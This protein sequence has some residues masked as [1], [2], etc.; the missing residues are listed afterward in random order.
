[1]RG[2]SS[3][4]I[5]RIWKDGEMHGIGKYTME[6]GRYFDGSFKTWKILIHAEP[7][8]IHINFEVRN[9]RF[10]FISNYLTPFI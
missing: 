10:H 1:M 9:S 8:H 7:I 5:L 6:D 3:V 4:R 2:K